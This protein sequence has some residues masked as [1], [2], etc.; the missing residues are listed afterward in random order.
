MSSS[1]T[2]SQAGSVSSKPDQPGP[3]PQPE[4]GPQPRLPR[5]GPQ[6]GLWPKCGASAAVFRA[7][8]ILLIER[9]KGAL[10]GR[11]SLPGGHIEPGER[12]RMAALRETREE[13]GIT[14][15]LFGLV[16]LH[17]VLL[18]GSDQAL[19]SHYVLAV[20]FGRW[21]AGEPAPA[22]DAASARFVDLED[23]NT[24]AL[25]QGAAPLIHRAWTLLQARAP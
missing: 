12:A 24:Y 22:S 19:T 1:R 21:L 15:E 18:H 9:G 3:W 5:Q 25:T 10:Q 7:Q 23:L 11:W 8:Q 20:Y 17:E 4:G 6:P 14:A 13:T 2:P 16:D